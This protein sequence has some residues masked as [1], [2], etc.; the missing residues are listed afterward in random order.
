MDEERWVR[1]VEV[2]PLLRWLRQDRVVTRVPGRRALR[3]LACGWCR[4][5]WQHIEKGPFR[6]AV[7]V[8][9]RFADQQATEAELEQ[10]ARAA[11]E[12]RRNLREIDVREPGP[13]VAAHQAALA[14]AV[15]GGTWSLISPSRWSLWMLLD[16]VARSASCAA[17]GGAL[18]DPVSRSWRP[19]R[20]LAAEEETRHQTQLLRDIFG[21][22]FRPAAIEQVW[23]SANG[24]MAVRLAEVIY[25]E[26]RFD[27][28]PILADALE[29]AD[30]N[31]G[32]ILE[33]CRVPGT[34]TRGCWV[35][36]AVRDPSQG[37][38]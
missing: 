14:T 34:H 18:F 27:E 8:A 7:E 25:R 1:E 32:V 10:A 23:R 26:R 15:T 13:A 38:R 4:R 37:T 11:G 31:D 20:P 28:L 29:D 17:G 21:N 3:L 22:P 19:A 6:Q 24:G 12:H 33:H 30:C 36:D 35:V 2:G 9:E 16:A 5:I